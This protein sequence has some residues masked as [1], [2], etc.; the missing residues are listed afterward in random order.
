MDGGALLHK[1]KWISN[2]TVRNVILQY[3]QYVK[4]KYGLRCV[5]FDGQDDKPSI[6][7][8]E[9]QRRS[10][11]ASSYIK[12]GLHNQ[13][14]CSQ[15]A[16]LK[17]S[18]NKAKFIELLSKHLANDE[19]NIRNSKGDAGTLIVSTAIQ[20]TKKQD[21]E[22]VVVVNDTDIRVLLIYN[23]KS[24]KLFMHS[25]FTKKNGRE[26]Q[27]WKIEDAGLV[28]G[29]EIARHILYIQA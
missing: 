25:E 26:K 12:V 11:N 21:N 5:V 28:L 10:R 27:A 16:F 23:W 2:S 14:S 13:I 8:H 3:S 7:D 1:I 20:Y 18:K 17:N 22:V 15:N 19:H 6:K 9:H 24:M 29:N 4:F